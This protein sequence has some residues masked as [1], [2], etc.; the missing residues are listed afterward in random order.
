VAVVW[1][2]CGSCG[3]SEVGLSLCVSWNLHPS[4][5]LCALPALPLCVSHP[6]PRLT[7]CAC[8]GGQWLASGSDDGSMRVWE[9]ASGRCCCSWQLGG[10]VVCVAW[11]PNP[12]LQLLAAAVG[13]KLVLLPFGLAGDE[14]EEAAKAACQVCRQGVLG[15][16]RCECVARGGASLVRLLSGV[17]GDEA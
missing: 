14:V 3:V 16:S 8:A 7:V 4:N 6:P 13:N 1:Q 12:Q 17:A 5:R 15:G 11:C 9:V 2:L 10:A